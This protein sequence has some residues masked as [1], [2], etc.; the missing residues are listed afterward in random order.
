MLHSQAS[1]EDPWC[2]QCSQQPCHPH[3]MTVLML[4]A[5]LICTL[6]KAEGSS[7]CSTR[8]SSL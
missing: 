5:K 6:V 8:S 2:L 1:I 4:L 7:E 3:L